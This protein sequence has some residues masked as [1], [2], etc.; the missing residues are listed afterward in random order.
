MRTVDLEDIISC[1]QLPS[2]PPVAL[3][4]IELSQDPDAE[5]PA[6]AEVIANDQAL[7][8]KI[9]RTVNSSFYGLSTP[10]ETISRAMTYLGL[11]TI[12]SLVLG[13]SLVRISSDQQESNAL[14]DHWRRAVY[15]A[16][17][18]RRI[19]QELGHCDPEEAFIAALMQDIGGL[20][21]HVT[22]NGDYARLVERAG[23]DHFQL[24]AIE[25]S[26]LGFDHAAVGAKLAE[27]WRLPDTLVQIIRHH[28]TPQQDSHYHLLQIITLGTQIAEMIGAAGSDANA[29]NA[30]DASGTLSTMLERFACCGASWYDMN[31]E[32]TGTLV[33]RVTADAEELAD[34]LSVNVGDPPDIA[35]IM[36]RAEEVALMHQVRVQQETE[37][38]QRQNLTLTRLA[39]P[40]GLTGL[41]NRRRFDEE[42]SSHVERTINNGESLAVI[43][44]DADHFKQLND[45]HGH[46]AGDAVLIEM[47]DRINACLA[48]DGLACRYGGEEFVVMLPGT[49]RT[50]A[51]RVAEA[52]RTRMCETPVEL[53]G[54]ECEARAVDV[55]VS[56]GVAAIEPGTH[57]TLNNAT[58]LLKAADRA[59]YHAKLCGRNQVQVF[60]PARRQPRAA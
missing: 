38:L 60:I 31:P 23:H 26:E 30:N 15:G 55:T 34:L 12:K 46:Q 3:Q 2:L 7:T 1:Q 14:I 17:A 39:Q 56:L 32:D 21:M 50:E 57:E 48:D 49:G 37:R 51:A 29:K 36:T 11:N 45:V 28:H 16:T 8:A 4:V 10:C 24:P 19:A 58:V 44:I 54:I 18:A 33:E 53:S 27:R 5:L 42:L 40:C 59:M 47:A 22:M 9:L 41:A 35:A 13:F 25:R 20:A 6:I 52:I 43:F